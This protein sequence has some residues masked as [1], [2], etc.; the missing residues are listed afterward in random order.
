MPSASGNKEDT[1]LIQTL[2]LLSNHFAPLAAR[3]LQR[4]TAGPGALL[5]LAKRVAGW[6]RVY[7]VELLC[8][9]P[10][11]EE[12]SWL[13]RDSCDGDYL[14]GYFAG[15]VATSAHLHEAITAIDPDLELVDHTSRLLMI[16]TDCGGMGMTLKNYQPACHVLEAHA[17]HAGRLE[18]TARRYSDITHLADYLHR[19]AADELSWAPG[20]REQILARYLSL[21]DRDD[22]SDVARTA[23][24]A[25]DAHFTWLAEAKA[26]QL[27]LRAFKPPPGQNC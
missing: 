24:A 5:W 22:W 11:P 14:N 10:G 16:M 1:P 6:G 13:L 12:R 19:K 8:S 27:D 25:A 7:T 17:T 2:G 18:P 4:Q 23:L 20:Q 21:P 26:P 9:Y 3:S 15:Q